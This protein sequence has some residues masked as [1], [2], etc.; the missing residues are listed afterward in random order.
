MD[1]EARLRAGGR[2][3]PGRFRRVG[4]VALGAVARERVAARAPAA[5]DFFVVCR[6]RGSA[7]LAAFLR[8]RAFGF[9]AVFASPAPAKRSP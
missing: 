8:G 6:L 3:G 9:A 4:E 1:D 7:V 2:A 5:H